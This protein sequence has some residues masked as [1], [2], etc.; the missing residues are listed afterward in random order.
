MYAANETLLALEAKYST[1]KSQMSLQRVMKKSNH[2][3]YSSFALSVLFPKWNLLIQFCDPAISVIKD[4]WKKQT[5]MA[6]NRR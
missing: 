3:T 4:K 6:N 5:K 1:E 2:V